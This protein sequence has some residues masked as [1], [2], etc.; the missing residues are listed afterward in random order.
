MVYRSA[1]VVICTLLFCVPVFARALTVEITAIVPGC[2]NGYVESGE[3]CD[4]TNLAGSSCVSLGLVG[5]VLSCT[6]LC[7]FDASSCTS[8]SGGSGS[9]SGGGGGGSIFIPSTNVVFVGRAYP[10]STV[11]LLK[12]AQVVATTISGT[13]ASFQMSVSGMAGGNYIFSLYSQDK[14][15][16]RSALLTFPVSVTANVTTKVSGVFIAPTLSADKKE[17]RKGD[18]ITLFG[19]STP[20][21]EVTIS[22]NSEEEIF[23]RRNTDA[24]GA[25]VLQFDTAVLEIGGH[26][27]RSKASLAGEITDYGTTIPFT[28]GTKNVLA[29]APSHCA[30]TADVNTD[31]R[32]NLVDFSVL[33]FWY[34]KESPPA[35]VDIN[36][37]G[38]VTIVDFSIMAFH[39]T[40]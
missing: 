20:G 9:G 4:G 25:Y 19:Q 3:H 29:D 30:Q 27:A 1:G 14:T 40:S 39:W 2:G 10:G 34:K 13:D 26:H 23:V 21:S 38:K 22:I 33:A 32:V 24:Q 28:V 6:S 35:H 31:C 15:G 5:G 7:T 12:D 11:T 18:T 8:S 16:V 17:V 37:D 36:K